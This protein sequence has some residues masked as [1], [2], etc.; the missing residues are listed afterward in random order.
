MSKRDEENNKLV[1]ESAY[2]I[3]LKGVALLTVI[4]V[5]NLSESQK[6]QLLKLI[7]G[8]TNDKR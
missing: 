2:K 7:D 8:E 3:Y 1:I 6:E 5:F 4:K